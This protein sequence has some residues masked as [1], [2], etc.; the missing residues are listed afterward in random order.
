MDGYWGARALPALTVQ[1]TQSR[2]MASVAFPCIVDSLCLSFICPYVAVF[3]FAS[4]MCQSKNDLVNVLAGCR[5]GFFQLVTVRVI[6]LSLHWCLCKSMLD[7][8]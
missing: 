7:F 2:S 3:F 1:G 8:S 4:F 6:D 5:H